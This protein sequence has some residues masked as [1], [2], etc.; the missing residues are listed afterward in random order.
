[1]YVTRQEWVQQQ[2]VKAPKAS[3]EKRKRIA[4]LLKQPKARIP[5]QQRRQQSKATHVRSSV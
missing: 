4:L 5:K 3:E 2:L 1:M